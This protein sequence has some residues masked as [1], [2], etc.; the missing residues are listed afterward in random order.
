MGLLLALRVVSKSLRTRRF[1]SKSGLAPKGARLRMTPSRPRYR[2]AMT[3]PSI[4][5]RLWV[6]RK[7]ENAIMRI[8]IVAAATK[9]G[10][11]GRGAV[12]AIESEKMTRALAR[13]S[14]AMMWAHRSIDAHLLSFSSATICTCNKM[15]VCLRGSSPAIELTPPLPVNGR[16]GAHASAI[17]FSIALKRTL[18]FPTSAVASATAPSSV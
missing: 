3:Q 1:Q 8:R 7:L 17:F 12:V 10:I 16:F 14:A 18:R 13:G 11:C 9:Q 5:V 4:K 15:I 6:F 2:N